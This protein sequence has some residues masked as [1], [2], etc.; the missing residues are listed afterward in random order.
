MYLIKERI[1]LKRVIALALI[2]S[3]AFIAAATEHRES[4]TARHDQDG[5]HFRTVPGLEAHIS[6]KGVPHT[7]PP[8]GS[9]STYHHKN[10]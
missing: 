1:M 5:R 4:E 7:Y 9:G 3:A 6:S 2:S 8:I 10:S